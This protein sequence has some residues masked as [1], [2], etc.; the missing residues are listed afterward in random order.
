LVRAFVLPLDY[1]TS[2]LS[3]AYLAW[4]MERAVLVCA[5]VAAGSNVGLNLYGIPRY[6]AMAAAV[7]TLIS[8]VVYLGM[9]AWAGGPFS[10]ASSGTAATELTNPRS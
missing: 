5:V 3:N 4:S 9:L 6:G 2:Y 1:L 10:R 8:Y 7:N